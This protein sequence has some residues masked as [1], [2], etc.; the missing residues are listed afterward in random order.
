MGYSD[1]A[2][3]TESNLRFY[4]EKLCPV[5]DLVRWLSYEGE[6]PTGSLQRR[7]ISFTFQRDTGGDVSEFYMRWQSFEGHQQLQH[8]LS[9]RNNVPFKIDIGAIYNKPVTLMQLSGA[10]FHAVERELVFDIDMNDYD[11]LRT[12]CTDKR[13]CHK[14]WKFISIAAE[15]LTRSLKEDFGFNEI[16]WVYSGRRGIHG[17]ICDAKARSLP[18]EARSAIVDYLMLLSADSH[19][20]RVNI[21]GV[22]DHPAVNRAF[23]ICYRNFY[24]L[25]QEQ[26]FLVTEAHIQSSLEYITDRFPKARQLLQ[27]AL[28]TKVKNSVELFNE[29]CEELEVETP[30]EYRRK[31][32]G[33]NINRDAFPVAFKELVLA[34]SYPRLDAA[35][36]KDVGHL[37]KAPF[38]IHAK[39]G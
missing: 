22:E 4:Y 19:K 14:C 6:K 11:D 16:M 9:E 28:K 17:W 12:C 30:E 38:C 37:L 20:K 24:D 39:T 34:F 2:L 13:I 10:D 36:T 8:M 33:V 3:V 18:N 27:R 5:K 32:T 25:L 15:I 21:F 31:N 7:E 29:I 26:N 1:D 23:D 35:V